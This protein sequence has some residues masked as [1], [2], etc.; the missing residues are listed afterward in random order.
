MLGCEKSMRPD[1]YTRTLPD[2]S[3]VLLWFT[4]KLF[5]DTDAMRRGVLMLDSR[6][7]NNNNRWQKS[8]LVEVLIDCSGYCQGNRQQKCKQKAG[9]HGKFPERRSVERRVGKEWRFRW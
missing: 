7:D 4:F 1:R 2:F 5:I 6:L 3:G 9:F 8:R